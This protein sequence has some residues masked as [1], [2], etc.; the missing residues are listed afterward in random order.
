MKGPLAT[1][2]LLGSAT[3]LGFPSFENQQQPL[4]T[5]GDADLQVDDVEYKSKPLVDSAS[6]QK[7]INADRLLGHAKALFGIAQAGIPDYGHPTRVIGSAGHT[8]TLDYIYSIVSSLGGGK[9]GEGG[10][11]RVWNQTFP[12]VT[13]KVYEARLVL[14]DSVPA[15][16]Q[17]MSLTPPTHDNKPVFGALVLATGT[18]CEASDYPAAVTGAITLVR[19]G[20]CPFGQK[21]ELAGAA[22]AVA[23]VVYNSE[24]GPLSGTLGTPTAT[25]VATFGLSGADAAPLV[26]ALKKGSSLDSIAYMDSVV[27]TI[28]TTNILAQT[29]EGDPDNCVMLGGHSDSVPE[30]PGINDDG[31]GTLSLLEIATQLTHYRVN[32]CVRFAWWAAEEEGLLGSDYY[33]ATLPPAEN[34]KVRLFMDYDM[35]GSP[36]FAY[37]VYDALDSENPAGSQ[38]LRDLYIDW[39]TAQGLN[40]SLIPFDGRSD[41]DGFIRAGIPAGG[42]A[43]GAEGIKT[44]DE[45]A[46]FGGTAGDWYDPCYHQLCDDVANV[47]LTAWE[48]NTKLVAHSVATYA[49]S[50]DGF[51]KRTLDSVAAASSTYGRGHKYHG[52]K[53]IM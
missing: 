10:Y 16:A 31:S 33:A 4:A 21:S 27:S 35:L 28:H 46:L 34:L 8:G 7:T 41:Y 44:K 23:V 45:A 37:Q 36:N 11:Y 39:Y 1:A 52:G 47:N 19:R 30:G 51:P 24:D 50:F 40:Y 20:D 42:I 38:A 26:A 2:L 6:L 14:N 17:A 9:G 12:A 22:G 25:Q 13:G 29:V 5:T 53:L 15:S 32:N 18:G 3:A 48:L 49:I 43:T